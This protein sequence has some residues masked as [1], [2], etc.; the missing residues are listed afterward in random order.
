MTDQDRIHRWLTQADLE[1]IL[2][3][4][5]ARG[6]EAMREAAAV[7]ADQTEAP[8]SIGRDHGRHHVAGA[9]HAAKRIRALPVP[10]DK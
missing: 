5:F 8:A 9:Q 4:A 2:D 10:E 3:E 6:A 7:C 1:R